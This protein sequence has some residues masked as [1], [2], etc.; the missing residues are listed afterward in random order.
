MLSTGLANYMLSTFCSCPDVCVLPIAFV[1]RPLVLYHR[2]SLFALIALTCASVKKQPALHISSAPD[3]VKLCS[4]GKRRCKVSIWFARRV[5]NSR[6]AASRCCFSC[7]CW[8]P[9]DLKAAHLCGSR[10]RADHCRE[11]FMTQPAC[12]CWWFSSFRG[13]KQEDTEFLSL[14]P[15]L[16]A[17]ISSSSSSLIQC[18]SLSLSLP[19]SAAS[20]T[21]S[22][23]SV[24]LCVC[25]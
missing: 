3:S 25:L 18:V 23:L 19:P 13:L 14:F 8:R 11:R 17:F 15:L 9:G 24:C 21:F 4:H 20:H 7:V 22:S 1:P 6:P 2:D 12:N 5:H 16:A 10:E